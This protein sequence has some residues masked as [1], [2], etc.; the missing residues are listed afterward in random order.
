MAPKL[1]IGLEINRVP[2]SDLTPPSASYYQANPLH[3]VSPVES[4]LPDKRSFL[5]RHYKAIPF[6]LMAI[7][8]ALC[9]GGGVGAA[10]AVN[11]ARTACHASQTS[12]PETSP[13]SA[14]SASP[15]PTL[16]IAPYDLQL[17]P[18][19]T[20]LPLPAAQNFTY[21]ALQDKTTYDVIYGG[22]IEDWTHHVAETITPSFEACVETC[23]NSNELVAALGDGD[24]RDGWKGPNA[25]R[26]VVWVPGATGVNPMNCF[27]KGVMGEITGKAGQGP[28]WIAVRR[29]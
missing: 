11:N 26:A 7:I 24:G 18:Q 17:G 21:I 25:C 13:P 5:S 12:Q 4:G 28:Q 8:V 3:N 23:A 15:S 14:D 2:Y 9:V 10:L 1:R 6:T 29:G 19:I 22:N 20:A 27:L 16:S